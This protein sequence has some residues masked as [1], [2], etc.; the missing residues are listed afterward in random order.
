MGCGEMTT[1][2]Q[3][4]A[5]VIDDGTYEEEIQVTQEIRRGVERTTTGNPR[6][7]GRAAP[8]VGEAHSSDEAE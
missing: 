5:G 6:G 2:P 3:P 7:T 1:A 4:P 8:E